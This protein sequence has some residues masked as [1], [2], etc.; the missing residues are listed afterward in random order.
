MVSTTPA[1]VIIGLIYVY[2]NHT[3]S[4]CVPKIESTLKRKFCVGKEFPP[5]PPETA[6]TVSQ[7]AGGEQEVEGATA[8]VEVASEDQ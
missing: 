7:A 6:A 1:R 8:A 2:Y 5:L 3:I 4:L